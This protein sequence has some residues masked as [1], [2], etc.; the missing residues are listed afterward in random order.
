M[1][2]NTCLKWIDRKCNGISVKEYEAL[3]N[4]PDEIPWLCIYVLLMI[5]L[6]N[7]HLV[8]CQK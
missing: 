6:Q 8:I 4:E 5:W 3:V 2:C 7:S 1:K